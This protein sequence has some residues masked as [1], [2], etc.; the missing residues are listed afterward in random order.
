MIY[1]QKNI[2]TNLRCGENG[3]CS[4]LKFSRRRPQAQMLNRRK[5]ITTYFQIDYFSRNFSK[6]IDKMY[7][8]IILKIFSE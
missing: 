3:D 1:F 8:K 5:S 4:D 6:N 7:H 2:A